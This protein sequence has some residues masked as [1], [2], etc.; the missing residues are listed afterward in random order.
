MKKITI[1]SWIAIMFLLTVLAPAFATGLEDK[2]EKAEQE[3]QLLLKKAQDYR[4]AEAMYLRSRAADRAL[5]RS[6]DQD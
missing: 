3:R 2:A 4:R 6:Q 5:H 1:I